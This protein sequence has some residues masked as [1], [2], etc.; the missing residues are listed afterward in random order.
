MKKFL[1]TLMAIIMVFAVISLSAC[2]DGKKDPVKIKEGEAIS[3]DLYGILEKEIDITQYVDEKGAD[4]EYSGVIGDASI[5][6][7]SDITGKKFTITGL[8][9][10]ETTVTLNA[11]VNDIVKVA[12]SWT[13]NVVNTAPSSVPY[14]IKDIDDVALDLY[15]FQEVQITISEYIGINSPVDG[16]TSVTYAVISG[17]D[18]VASVSEI[19]SGV[20]TI[21][22]VKVG[23]ALLTLTALK[24][25]I[26]KVTLEIIVNVIDTTP[27]YENLDG[28]GN[29]LLA[30]TDISDIHF[31]GPT[32]E[33]NTAAKVTRYV[34]VLKEGRR[35]TGDRLHASVSNGDFTEGYSA[36][37]DTII[38]LTKQYGGKNLPLITCYGNH[39]GIGKQTLFQSKLKYKP[40]S[41]HVVNGFTFI[42]TN[43]DQGYDA[44]S[45]YSYNPVTCELVKTE[46]QK[47][48]KADPTKPVFIVAH[49]PIKNSTDIGRKRLRDVIKEY[50]QVY[51][52]SGHN[53]STPSSSSFY[54]N[55]FHE[56]EQGTLQNGPFA[57][58]RVTDRNYVIVKLYT[59]SNVSGGGSTAVNQVNSL[60]ILDMNAFLTTKGVI[61]A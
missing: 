10:G 55:E 44:E 13:V 11:K 54:E 15:D 2:T 6:R 50:P 34:N 36:N 1:S 12:I 24:D 48:T 58:F 45:T 49:Y 53:H 27:N 5:V 29:V 60:Q 39:E 52:L 26:V 3:L 18:D 31:D 9:K 46:L 42:T 23:D 7:V 35:L 33:Q 25:S 19:V 16:D 14:K 57:I 4:V 41:A 32:E 30:F 20:F 28:Y 51:V 22:A 59:A 40:D 61:A 8:K 17:A 56:F 21:A 47:A 37:Y 38:N 43:I